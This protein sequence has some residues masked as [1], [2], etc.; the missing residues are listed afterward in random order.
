[1]ATFRQPAVS[2]LFYPKEKRQLEEQ[3][4]SFLKKAKKEDWGKPKILI[5]PHAGIVYSGQT[6]AFGFKQVEGEDFK[7][8][9]LLGASHTSWFSYAAVD[10][11][12]FWLTPLGQVALDKDFIDF[13]TD[14][15]YVVKDKRP[16]I[17]EHCL[18]MELI[19]LQKVLTNFK[20][21]PILLSEADDFLMEKLAEKLAKKIDDKTLIVVSS[22]LSHYPPDEVAK[23]ADQKTIEAILS[24]ERK[25]FEKKIFEVENSG[26]L[27]LETAACGQK[28]ISVALALAKRLGVYFKLLHYSN[29][30]D[31]SLDFSRVVGYAAIGGYLRQ[32]KNDE[33]FFLDEEAQKEALKIVKNT[34]QSFLTKGIIPK[35]KVKSKSLFKNLGCFV[36]LKKNGKLR[37]CIGEFP[38]DK[39]LWQVIQKTALASAFDDPRFFPLKKEELPFLEIE[40]SIVFPL[41]KI[42][43]WRKIKLGE[44]GVLIEKEG[45]RGVFLPQVAKETG[46]SLEEFLAHL[47]LEKAGLPSNC[48]KDPKTNIYVFRVQSFLGKIN[49]INRS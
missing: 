34:W 27:G 44:E 40:I 3:I 5:V 25:I 28:A 42:D 48:Y 26:L 4:L 38:S 29:S 32:N 8:V 36:T 7:R 49:Q 35:I 9:F 43:D 19:F 45:R 37:G 2:G 23:K 46:W 15:K 16:F 14:G 12:D 24:G 30:G 6:A 31:V 21:V 39:P 20:I 41:K 22:D 13:L 33:K 10:D 17:N 1:M 47:C 11:S 18:E